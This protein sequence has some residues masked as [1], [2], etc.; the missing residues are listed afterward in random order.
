MKYIINRN[1]QYS[2]TLSSVL[3]NGQICKISVKL[4]LQQIMQVAGQNTTRHK[5]PKET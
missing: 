3:Q 5:I 2:T 1:F 4:L